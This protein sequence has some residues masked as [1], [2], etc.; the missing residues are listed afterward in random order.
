MPPYLKTVAAVVT[1]VIG[2]ATLVV[3]SPSTAVT[4]SEWIVLATVVATAVGV[5]VVPNADPE[6]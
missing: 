1:G 4:A 2:W 3:N 5:Y 6:V